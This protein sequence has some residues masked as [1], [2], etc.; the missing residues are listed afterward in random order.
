MEPE[1]I[2][3]YSTDVWE[4]RQ[5]KIA[6]QQSMSMATNCKF[7][8]ATILLAIRG[9]H[10]SPSATLNNIAVLDILLCEESN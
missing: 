4:V 5:V 7:V 3:T 8:T 1:A 2:K 9:V 6:K 10:R